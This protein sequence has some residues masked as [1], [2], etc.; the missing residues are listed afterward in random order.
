[1]STFTSLPVAVCPIFEMGPHPPNTSYRPAVPFRSKV[2][3]L[4]PK[5]TAS[6]VLRAQD[7]DRDSFAL[8]TRTYL[9]A[10][11]SVALAILRRPSDAEDVAQDSLLLAFERLNSCREPERFAGWFLQIVRNQARNALT[12][13][14]LRDVPAQEPS[15]EV[16]GELATPDSSTYRDHLLKALG[17]LTAVRRE[18]VLLHDLEGWTHPE[19]ASA[20]QISELMSRQHLFVARRQLR[21]QLDG[22]ISEVEHA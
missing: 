3:V 13:R 20:L 19:I 2:V 12:S 21:E 22:G 9:R 1:M 11:Y 7:G 10:A 15:E 14:K 8:L 5:D 18:V 16:S 17:K 6:L 4:V